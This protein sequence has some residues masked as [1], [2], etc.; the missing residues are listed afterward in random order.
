[1]SIVNSL[2]PRQQDLLNYTEN[3]SGSNVKNDLSYLS[4]IQNRA[5]N[6]PSAK[7]NLTFDLGQVASKFISWVFAALVAIVVFEFMGMRSDIKEL[8]NT[9]TAILGKIDALDTKFSVAVQ[10][11]EDI[12]LNT[13]K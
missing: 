2:N 5:A 3:L 1:M 7:P 4:T 8:N 6:M 10:R 13:K 12:T 11:L 9:N